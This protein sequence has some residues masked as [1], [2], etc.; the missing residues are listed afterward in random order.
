MHNLRE[1]RLQLL[2]FIFLLV[3]TLTS[4]CQTNESLLYNN[5]GRLRIDTSL[6][7]TSYQLEKWKGIE[8]LIINEI[9][10]RIS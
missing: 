8:D 4:Y 9:I 6:V 1:M 3:F 5:S 2:L 10:G 7:I